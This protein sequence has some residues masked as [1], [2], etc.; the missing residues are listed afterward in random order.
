M[1][2]RVA[3]GAGH[4]H[5]LG[6]QGNP[7]EKELNGRKVHAVL[8]MWESLGGVTRTGIDLRSYTP[9]EG[10]GLY[11]GYLNQA[12]ASLVNSAWRPDMMIELHSEG[13]ADPGT[14]GAFVIF[15]DW[16]ID[17]DIDVMASGLIFAKR[18]Q[19]VTGGEIGIRSVDGPGLMSER[20]TGVGLLGYRLGVFRDTFSA[21]GYCTRLI[22]EQ[23]A[24]SNPGERAYMESAAFLE[25]QARA[26][27]SSIIEFA[28]VQK[29][30]DYRDLIPAADGRPMHV[31]A[32]G[33]VGDVKQFG[34]ATWKRVKS[35]RVRIDSGTMLYGGFDDRGRVPAFE[36][37]G[38]G[39]FIERAVSF[40][41]QGGPYL[42]VS[43]GYM[44][45][46]NQAVRVK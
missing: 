11:P 24:H 2:I 25:A 18:L 3:I 44:V 14:K 42:T 34:G 17:R 39:G 27:I 41:Q 43:G 15:P 32:G 28:Q 5:T 13:V 6:E 21:R 7:F 38:D 20:D 10:L 46:E 30:G 45:R 19:L 40:E 23:G 29:I 9:N 4:R 12:P 1:A 26:L 8:E 22:L 36:V 16:G 33:R 35:Y 31:P 37:D